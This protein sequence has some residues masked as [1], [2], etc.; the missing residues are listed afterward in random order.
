M[1]RNNYE[2]R[3]KPEKENTAPSDWTYSGK[4]RK[5]QETGIRAARWKLL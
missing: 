4:T 3:F 5:E 1:L 2:R